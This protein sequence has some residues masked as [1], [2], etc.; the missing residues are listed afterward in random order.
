MG[1]GECEPHMA[2]SM[3]LATPTHAPP[4]TT[5]AGAA[6]TSPSHSHSH[7]QHHP[8]SLSSG[9]HSHFAHLPSNSRPHTPSSFGAGGRLYLP[10]RS[11]SLSGLASMGG[12]GANGASPSPG[13][14]AHSTL[15]SSSLAHTANSMASYLG[16]SGHGGG[17]G[18]GGYGNVAASLGPPSS[19]SIP[20]IRVALFSLNDAHLSSLLTNLPSTARSTHLDLLYQY[21][22]A[23]ENKFPRALHLRD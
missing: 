4:A 13:G 10:A 19:L 7:S 11:P 18:G 17:G 15:S 23:Y 14:S 9:A 20:A 2:L 8:R 21:V 6:F 22:P 12:G 16:H 3:M 5:A 1:M